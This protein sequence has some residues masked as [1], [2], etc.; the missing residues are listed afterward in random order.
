MNANTSL[1]IAHL[2]MLFGVDFGLQCHPSY[3]GQPR[4]TGRVANAREGG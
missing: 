4:R 3:P 2:L 1:L